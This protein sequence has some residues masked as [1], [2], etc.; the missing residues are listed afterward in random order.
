MCLQAFSSC[1]PWAL[2]CP[3]ISKG[4]TMQQYNEFN[5]DAAIDGSYVVESDNLPTRYN[6]NRASRRASVHPALMQA[7]TFFLF[8]AG[9]IAVVVVG[10]GL[11]TVRQF[12]PLIGLLALLI[13]IILLVCAGAYAVIS[14]LRYATRA[15]FYPVEENGAYLRNALGRTTPLAP[16]IAAPA[17]V[18][19]ATNK[20]EITPAV[21]TL[22]DLI[23][24]GE[25]APGEMNMVMGYDAAQLRK[26]ILQLVVSTWPG[27]HVVAGKGRSGK[28]RRVI[29]MIAQALINGARVIVCDPHATK[30]DSLARSLEPLEKYLTIARNEAQIVEISREFLSEME[31]RIDEPGRPC[32]PWLIVYDEWSRLMDENNLKMP[33]GG[34]EILIDAAKNCSTQYAGY[35][36]Y[37]CMI[38]QIWTQQA[39]G[40]TDIRRSLQ[41]VF[42]HQLSAEYAAFFFRARK[43]Q[44]KAEELKKRECIYRD[45]EN[46]VSEILTIGVP[47]DTASRVAVY[48]ASLGM[49][50]APASAN[51]PTLAPAPYYPPLQ[52][53][54]G[55]Q[56]QIYLPAPGYDRPGGRDEI[57]P[58]YYPA[59][60]Q[61]FEREIVTSDDGSAQEAGYGSAQEA[62]R[63]QAEVEA[64][65]LRAIAKRLRKGETPNDIRKSLG[66]AGGRALQEVNAALNILGEQDAQGEL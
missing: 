51:A 47:D 18:N 32:L 37:C 66:I 62:P 65:A 45:T 20:V 7:R 38:G 26:G 6:Q 46:Q 43:W 36:G 31:A 61:V 17:R 56:A 13:A 12:M 9:T 27:T 58:L 57:E 22:F 41:S 33:E 48:L 35:L 64:E 63:K 60:N 40:G 11:F 14:V 28:T 2:S 16:M 54:P 29:A 52:D 1:P 34:R 42:V 25:I 50:E 3:A 5:Q 59:S 30:L 23:E 49:I 10:W 8:S 53:R 19:R 55:A 4:H 24:A 21:P 44:G 39:C 15:D